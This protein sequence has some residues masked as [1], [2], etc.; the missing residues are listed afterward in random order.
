MTALPLPRTP[1]RSAPRADRDG[2]ARRLGRG[3]ALAAVILGLTLRLLALMAIHV[4]GRVV[5]WFRADPRRL[6]VAAVGLAF[7][8]L[9]G[10]FLG[11]V[12]GTGVAWGWAVVRGSVLD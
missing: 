6:R 4:A 3:V 1:D 11:W 2:A 9:L 12:L 5:T 10:A 8:T 7:A